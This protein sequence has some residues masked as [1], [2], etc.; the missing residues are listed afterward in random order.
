MR[1]M[2]ATRK[3][4]GPPGERRRALLRVRVE[5]PAFG[6]WLRWVEERLPAAA[7]DACAAYGVNREE[8]N[9]GVLLDLVHAEM[10]GV[11]VA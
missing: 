7:L 1:S 4:E 10:L 3:E 11:D 9:G 2:P 6:G 8:T 5:G